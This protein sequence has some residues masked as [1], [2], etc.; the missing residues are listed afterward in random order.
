MV[1]GKEYVLRARKRSSERIATALRSRQLAERKGGV[2]VG[3]F[4]GTFAI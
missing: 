3:V 2:L 1:R 4:G